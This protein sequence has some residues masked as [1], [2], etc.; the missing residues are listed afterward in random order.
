MVARVEGGSKSIDLTPETI[1]SD[2]G[3]G[4]RRPRR[5]VLTV[6]AA[7]FV[8]CG[9]L[10]AGAL[11]ASTNFLEF[12]SSP[13][14]VG[15]QPRAVIA[16][17]LDDDGDQDLATANRSS[18]NVT[19]LRNSGTGNY[20]QPASSPE[21]AGDQAFSLVAA[22]LDGDTDQD[23]AV[24]NFAAGSVTILR[25]NGSGNF[26][27][28]ASSPETVGNS[29]SSVAASDLDDDG[30]QDLAVANLLSNNVTIL[31]NTGTGNFNEPASSPEGV[32]SQ[33]ISLAAGN[34]DGDGDDD[35]AV[36]SQGSGDVTILRNNGS[37]NFLE[38]ASSPEG[39]G[40]FPAS[41]VATDLDGDTDRDLAVAN[42]GSIDL[43]VLRNN[44]SGNFV[45]P[46]S[47]PEPIGGSPISVTSA[48]FDD[49]GD[50]DVAVANNASSDVT[51]L[52][53]NGLANFVQP[54]SSPEPAGNTPFS[55][56]AADLDAD[57][58]ADLAVANAG[59][60]TVTLL[61]NR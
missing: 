10:A 7:G 53:N 6:V 16:A 23:L 9:A 13:E 36:A 48:D 35:L 28:A 50:Q 60:D 34:L 61:R 5:R 17:D 27:P 55:V 54:A 42:A 32:G 43:T 56:T 12:P 26:T 3:V 40:G 25:N 19:I 38:P 58:D 59:I 24:A 45:E 46:A 51:V 1:A 8:A 15:D 21:S 30:D 20:V 11:A 47:S 52:R 57:L 33:P 37:G 39:A 44:G 22:D 14:T 31:K 29:P 18:D 2:P 41:V 49:D 4:V